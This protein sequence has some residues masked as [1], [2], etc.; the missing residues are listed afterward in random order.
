L[1]YVNPVGDDAALVSLATTSSPASGASDI[2]MGYRP[3]RLS[4]GI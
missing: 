2:V 1:D 3:Q 4:G